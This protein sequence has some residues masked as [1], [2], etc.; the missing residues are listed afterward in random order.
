[1]TTAVTET[2][3]NNY[4]SMSVSEKALRALINARKFAMLVSS[5][6]KAKNCYHS[7]DCKGYGL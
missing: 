6:G 2:K 3:N 5:P 1:M 4:Q 7:S